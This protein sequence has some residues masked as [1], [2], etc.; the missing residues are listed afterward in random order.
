[1]VSCS[2]L[3]VGVS[4]LLGVN[5]R[6]RRRVVVPLLLALVLT[7]GYGVQSPFND[8]AVSRMA[9][10]VNLASE[11]RLSIEPFHLATVDKAFRAG[12]YYSDKAP[13]L[14]FAAIPIVSTVMT[15]S[16]TSA[17]DLVSPPDR[18]GALLLTLRFA[19]LVLVATPLL[20]GAS[21]AVAACALYLVARRL[22]REPGAALMSA[23]AFALGTPAWGWAT[24]FFGH[25]LAG[26]LA[27]S[28][29]AWSI[30][31][32][33]RS[34]GGV[35]CWVPVGLLLGYSVVTEYPLIIPATVVTIVAALRARRY[36]ATTAV[37]TGIALGATA[38][39]IT[40]LAYN[41]AVAGSWF[42]VA[43]ANVVGFEG[44]Q[45][46]C[47]G[48][49][50]PRG[51][52]LW[53]ILLSTRRGLLLLSPIIAVVPFAFW[54]ARRAMPHA[55][56]CACLGI[57]LYFVLFNASYEYW[58]GGYSTGP[59]HLT[60]ALAFA[61]FPL[62]WAW[63]AR[64]TRIAT[65][66]TLAVSLTISCACAST[67][68]AAPSAIEWPLRDMV[69]PMVLAGEVSNLSSVLSQLYPSFRL[70]TGLGS[71]LPLPVL[72]G[73]TALV[74]RSGLQSLTGRSAP[75]DPD[76]TALGR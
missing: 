31:L 25:A 35:L 30:F 24:A 58:D 18:P 64:R 50:Y 48:L 52:A 16:G 33:E 74:I 3:E 42:R 27:F 71:L 5:A 62:A 12:R 8:N 26:A 63:E 68:M 14:S 38:P 7:Y 39:A 22:G 44:M 21:T 51:E 65:I 55:Y 69:L 76:L 73:T 56:W 15:I 70:P 60:P 9:L 23:L 2:V 57:V 67:T 47:L 40:L 72:W 75:I 36:G 46:G 6:E 10:A 11:G 32:L 13:G 49:T 43:Y 28:A 37:V 4:N 17:A 20:S 19:L 1:M 53:G 61:C 54:K 41:D 66:A 34:R 45:E 59:R 29:F